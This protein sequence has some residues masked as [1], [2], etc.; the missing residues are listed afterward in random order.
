MYFFT[1]MYNQCT[2]VKGLHDAFW[3]YVVL[4][5]IICYENYV[6]KLACITGEY[7]FRRK[8]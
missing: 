1:K 5:I 4:K 6:I 3:L 2:Y 8:C 7:D